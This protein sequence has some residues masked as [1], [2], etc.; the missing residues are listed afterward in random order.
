VSQLCKTILQIVRFS[1]QRA[2]VI[3]RATDHGV[4][5][6]YHGA[7]EVQLLAFYYYGPY[8]ASMYGREVAD[9]VFVEH[10]LENRPHCGGGA[11]L[12]GDG[13]RG[14]LRQKITGGA[15][16]V[17]FFEPRLRSGL[18]TFKGSNYEARRK[19]PLRCQRVGGRAT[20]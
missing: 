16:L 9:F 4:S 15:C 20:L 5:A 17:A 19:H 11:F 6:G 18:G 14:S 7:I 12:L 3:Q 1:W 13:F 2:S 10:E 8:Y